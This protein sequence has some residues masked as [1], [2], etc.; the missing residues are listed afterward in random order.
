MV[1]D[2]FFVPSVMGRLRKHLA[3]PGP[4]NSPITRN[5]NPKFVKL[6][7]D[8]KDVLWPNISLTTQG[9]NFPTFVTIYATFWS[10]WVT[11]GERSVSVNITFTNPNHS[12]KR[13]FKISYIMVKYVKVLFGHI[14]N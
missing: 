5:Y 13:H 6:L 4:A 2:G 7:V 11:L 8:H 12:H 14:D 10:H 9:Q 3:K 1:C